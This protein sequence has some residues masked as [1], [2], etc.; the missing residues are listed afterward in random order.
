[1]RFFLSNALFVLCPSTVFA[2]TADDV[3]TLKKILAVLSS[4]QRPL[5]AGQKG[6]TAVMRRQL[7]DLTAQIADKDVRAEMQ[8]LIADLEPGYVVQVRSHFVVAE[9]KRMKG[10]TVTE[11]GGPPWKSSTSA[12]RRSPTT[13]SS[14][15]RKLKSSKRWANKTSA[16]LSRKYS[17]LRCTM[18]LAPVSSGVS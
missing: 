1:M 3:G 10:K 7:D 8:K 12:S 17:N 16:N 9:V 11:P 6:F 13:A 14:T 4:N 2:G 5:D 18:T 15:W